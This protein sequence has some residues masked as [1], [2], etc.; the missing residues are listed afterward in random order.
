MIKNLKLFKTNEIYMRL[1]LQ[2]D[3][4]FSRRFFPSRIMVYLLDDRAIYL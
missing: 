2:A 4:L 3:K 1:A